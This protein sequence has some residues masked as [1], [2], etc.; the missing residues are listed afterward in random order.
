[1]I[2]PYKHNHLPRPNRGDALARARGTWPWIWIKGHRAT[3]HMD[4]GARALWTGYQYNP[5]AIGPHW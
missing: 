4:A 3:I 5:Y 1:M 2:L